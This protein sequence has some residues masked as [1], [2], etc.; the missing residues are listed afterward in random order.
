MKCKG[1]EKR[2]RQT[3]SS[4]IIGSFSGVEGKIRRFLPELKVE[5]KKVE[6]R[7]APVMLFLS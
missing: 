4:A 6:K 3:G 1:K 5:T 2:E 7:V